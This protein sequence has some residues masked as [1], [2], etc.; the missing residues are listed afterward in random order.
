MDMDTCLE[1][2]MQITQI[3]K[4]NLENNMHLGTF[5]LKSK[6]LHPNTITYKGNKKIRNINK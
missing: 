1:F 6:G 5:F 3:I 2:E 4:D